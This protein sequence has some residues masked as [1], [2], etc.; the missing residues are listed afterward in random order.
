MQKYNV[1]KDRDVK[2]WKD[3]KKDNGDCKEEKLIAPEVRCPC[4]EPLVHI[5]KRASK[6]NELPREEEK[7][8]G[9]GCVAC[10]P[11]AEHIVT[12]L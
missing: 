2:R 12:S 1:I 11:S 7:D 8:P 9:H 5:E 6:V 10:S 3:D 4:F